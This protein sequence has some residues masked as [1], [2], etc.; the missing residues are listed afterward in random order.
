LVNCNIQTTVSLCPAAALDLGQQIDLGLDARRKDKD[1][2]RKKDKKHKSSRSRLDDS[3][4]DSVCPSGL[5]TRI[6]LPNF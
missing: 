3:F 5:A 6:K 1:K 4:D 2:K